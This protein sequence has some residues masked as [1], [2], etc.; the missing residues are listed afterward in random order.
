V[1]P[2]GPVGPSI[3]SK[4]TLYTT[5]FDGPNDPFIFVSS[6]IVIAPV[7]LSYVLT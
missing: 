3:P 4:F 2:V 1:G 5:V 7:I 6:L